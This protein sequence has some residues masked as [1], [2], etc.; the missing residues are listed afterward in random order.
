MLVKIGYVMK[1]TDFIRQILDLIDGFDNEKSREL[2]QDLSIEI[3]AGAPAGD[4]IAR[5][6]Q[7][8]DLLGQDQTQYSNEPCEKIADID[9]VT[10]NAGGGVNGPKHPADIRANSVSMYPNYQHDPRNS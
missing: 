5:F 10:Q 3:T 2:P 4:E 9:A 6:K 8:V 1:A 7:I